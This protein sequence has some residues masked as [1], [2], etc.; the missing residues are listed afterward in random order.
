[1]EKSVKLLIFW[2]VWAIWN[3]CVPLR[4][5]S[6][7]L[8]F[9]FLLFP[10]EKWNAQILGARNFDRKSNLKWSNE[11]HFG[12]IPIKW[13]SLLVICLVLLQVPKCFV[14]VQIFWA[15]PNIWLHLVPLQKLV[16]Q[17]KK[18]FYWMQIIF[19]SGTK[20]LWL[21]QYVNKFL[22]WH[23]KFGPSKN[24]LRP[25]KGQGINIL[26]ALEQSCR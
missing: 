11:L 21:T 3:H 15:S 6:H 13:H 17:H 9:F 23:K 12:L 19:L 5:L 4:M 14:P 16:C 26:K 8:S 7:R 1:M 25:V 24:I 18:Q 2:W 22:V 20:C 10:T